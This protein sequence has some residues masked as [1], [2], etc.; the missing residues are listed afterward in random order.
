MERWISFVTMLMAAVFFFGSEP[1]AAEFYKVYG[2]TTPERGKVELAYW[3]THILSSS[4]RHSFFGRSKEREGLLAHSFEAELGVTDHFTLAA[5]LDAEDPRGA[6]LHYTQAKAVF[7]RYR[8]FEK[9]TLPLDSAI[10]LEY[11]IPDHDY[12]ESEE[13][14]ARIIGE[15]DFRNLRIRINP[16]FEKKV[17]GETREGIEFN[18]GVGI[19]WRNLLSPEA[20]ISLV[21]GVELHGKMGEI[22]HLK[23]SRDQEHYL[24]PTLDLY[25]TKIKK[26][27]WHLGMGPGLTEASDHFLVKS[28]FSVEL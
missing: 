25:F 14:E 10:Y 16:I 1:A 6:G 15:K 27:H 3:T 26:F 2:Y 11:I 7:C 8:F 19:Y 18:Y 28:I 20:K 22:R 21:P 23:S 4:E 17:S 5:Y 9:G 13:L 12:R 24:F